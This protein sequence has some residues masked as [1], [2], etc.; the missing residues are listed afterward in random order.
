MTANTT[1]RTLKCAMA[2]LC[3]TTTAA[4]WGGAGWGGASCGVVWCGVVRQP[5][6]WRPAS[7][8]PGQLL[9][10][11]ERRLSASIRTRGAHRPTAGGTATKRVTSHVT[12][13]SSDTAR[14][15]HTASCAVLKQC[16]FRGEG[17]AKSVG[18][19]SLALSAFSTCCLLPGP[20]ATPPPP[21]P[22]PSPPGTP[23]QS[24]SSPF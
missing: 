3:S 11:A 22:P 7:V 16:V 10:V 4:G 6:R 14:E 21:P 17:H 20:A 24:S 15:S 1:P 18:Y 12:P 19:Y 8:T 5:P 23:T 9:A 13:F 2:S